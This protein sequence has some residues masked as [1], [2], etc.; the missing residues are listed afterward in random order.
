MSNEKINKELMYRV[1]RSVWYTKEEVNFLELKEKVILVK[2]GEV[3]DRPRILNLSPWL[4]DQNLF[5][6]TLYVKDKEIEVYTFNLSP[7]WVRIYN[8]LF[9]QMDRQTTLEVG[10]AI[11]EVMEGKNRYTKAPKKSGLFCG[12]RR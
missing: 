3:D 6:L 1:L 4:F 11:G 10:E 7:F 9:D 5:S 8:I 2:F 12:K